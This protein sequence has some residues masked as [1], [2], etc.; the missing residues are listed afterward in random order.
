MIE[1]VLTDYL[2]RPI[3]K[4]R[5]LDIGCGNGDISSYFF[6]KNRQYGVDIIDSR[7]ERNRA[8]SFAKVNSEILPFDNSFFDIVISHHVIEH[9]YDQFSHLREIRRV[10]KENG[11]VYLATPNKSSPIMKGHVDNNMVLKYRE[12][13]PLF[14][15]NGFIPYEYGILV[16]KEPVKFNCDI[17]TAKVLPRFLL[18]KL[19]PMFPSH[20]FILAPKKDDCIV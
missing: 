9:V 11:I 19:R 10:L 15:E 5:I 16:I 6:K 8:F 4:F 14:V 17:K 1:S 18:E 13:G 3:E 20:I 7:R 12:M 2:N